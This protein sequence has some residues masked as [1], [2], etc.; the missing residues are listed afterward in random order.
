MNEQCK[1]SIKNKHII[2]K[3]KNCSCYYCL[4]TYETIEIREYIDDNLT[5]L[6]PYCGIDAVVCFK[7]NNTNTQ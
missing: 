6:C 2:E 7:E 5:A 4:K 1:L 3:Y